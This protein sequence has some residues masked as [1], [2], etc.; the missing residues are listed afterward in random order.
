[1]AT[2][3]WRLQSERAGICDLDPSPRSLA[4]LNRPR[5]AP[6]AP[7]A[8]RKASHGLSPAAAAPARPNGLPKVGSRRPPGREILPLKALRFSLPPC[9]AFSITWG[10][11]RVA[12]CARQSAE[13]GSSSSGFRPAAAMK[14][15]ACRMRRPSVLKRRPWRLVRDQSWMATGKTSR[16]SRVLHPD[17]LR[18]FLQHRDSLR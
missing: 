5:E 16:R 11:M 3:T 12:R 7:S 1:M 4:L 8:V 13:R 10:A 15:R 17:R 14:Y 6:R 9:P 2:R 18:A